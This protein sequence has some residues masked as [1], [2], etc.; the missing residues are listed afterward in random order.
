VSCCSWIKLAAHAGLVLGVL[1]VGHASAT[2]QQPGPAQTPLPD[3]GIYSLLNPTPDDKLR[4]FSTDRPTKSNSPYTVD[5][6]H[7][8]YESDLVNYTESHAGTSRIHTLEALD[9]NWKLGVTGNVDLELDLNGY[10]TARAWDAA[11]GAYVARGAGFGDIYFR[12]KINLIGNDG[13][14]VALAV[15]PYVKT[16]TGV[17]LVSNGVVEGGLIAPLRVAIND[18]YGVILMTEADTLKDATSARRHANFTNL[19]NFNGPI[20]G[21]KDLTGYVEFYSAAG[22]DRGTPPIYTADLALSYNITKTLQI[23]VG[24]NFGLNH[25]APKLQLYSGLSQRF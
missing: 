13:G 24:T 12:S 6:G 2:A 20:P 7:F 23:D 25:A 19:V 4:S 17:N 21:L 18:D 9:P 14:P 16:P 8:Q 1:C 5:A 11:T 22:T 10:Q 15:I 3:I